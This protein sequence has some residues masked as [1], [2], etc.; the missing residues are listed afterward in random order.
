MNQR[1]TYFVSF[2]CSSQMFY[3]PISK[4]L[5]TNPDLT[6][7]ETST[8]QQNSQIINS[9]RVLYYITKDQLGL[10]YIALG[11]SHH[12]KSGTVLNTYRRLNLGKEISK[13]RSGQIKVTQL[14]G[15]Y[16]V[17]K[18]INQQ[19]LPYD[20]N[21]SSYH[22]VMA[23]DLIEAPSYMVKKVIHS[24]P[25]LDIPYFKLFTEPKAR[26]TNIELSDSGKEFLINAMKVFGSRK[27]SHIFISGYTGREGKTESNQVESYQRALTIRQYL[28]THLGF[29]PNRLTAIGMGET[30]LKDPSNVSGHSQANR[31]IVIKANTSASQ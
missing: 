30:A 1:S 25:E 6:E 22:G 2:L 14:I 20:T 15:S 16:A 13:F 19:E 4:G 11:S 8:S 5:M 9:K 24:L 21:Y 3:P 12:I 28:I 31:R 10:V 18:V 29:D 17:A 7:S 27:V 23:G 26:P